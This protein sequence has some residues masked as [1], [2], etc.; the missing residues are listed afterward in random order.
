[1]NKQQKYLGSANVALIF[2]IASPIAYS[3]DVSQTTHHEAASMPVTH[4]PAATI[5]VE[6]QPLMINSGG[7]TV[8]F[9]GFVK[10]DA[11]QDID[12]IGNEDQFKV[13]SIPVSGD[14][15]SQ[16]GGSSHMTARATRFTMD[17]RRV[18]GAGNGLRAY[19]EG[20]FYGSGNSFR[21]RQGYGEWNGLL[22]GQTWSTFQDLSARPFT[23]D[24]EGPDGEV[25]VR[26]PQIRYTKSVSSGLQWS[27]AAEDPDS[28]IAA[29]GGLAGAGRSEVPDI[30]GN[31]RFSNANG[32][33][34]IGG[35]I[36][37][38]RFVSNDGSVDETTGGFGINLSGAT[39]IA[40]DD[41][42]MGHVA[43]GS[44]IG[45]YIESFG[46]TNSDAFISA[47]GDLQ[48][49]DG[50]AAVVGYTH[51]WTAMMSSTFSLSIAELD[52][53]TGQATDAIKSSKSSHLNIV[54]KPFSQ[55]LIGGELMWGE[56]EN[57]D[58]ASGDA[59]RL[60]LSAQYNFH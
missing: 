57:N 3:Q 47:T 44:G 11:M 54:Y 42:V 41:A 46:G 35:L 1:M 55:F 49:L 2:L 19:V 51:Q 16:L 22:L 30:T 20:D 17:V 58:G 36:R 32:H 7:V 5:A 10:L 56:R 6:D 31:L 45:R 39:K 26:Q 34:Q 40:G 43:F 8:Q 53:V 27:I 48:A 33:V 18:E 13:N 59:I 24:Y 12:P 60:Q 9:G 21:M 29:G 38:L 4:L 37:Q 23:W 14:P 50:W 25:F 52:N 28:E 15:N